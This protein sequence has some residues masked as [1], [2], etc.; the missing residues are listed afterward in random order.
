M[1]INKKKYW[2]ILNNIDIL[3]IV[4]TAPRPGTDFLH[5]LLDNHPEIISFD[6]WLHFH[7]FFYNSIT[8][9]GTKNKFFKEKNERFKNI[10]L[11]NFFYEFAWSHLH[12]FDSRYDN[13]EL[14]GNLGLKKNDFN[15]LDIDEFVKTAVTLIADQEFSCRN[16]MLAIYGSIIILRGDDLTTK[17]V[18]LHNVHLVDHLDLLVDDFP[19]VK[20]IACTR[21]PRVWATKINKTLDGLSLSKYSINMSRALFKL[22]IDSTDSL[23]LKKNNVRVN[24]LERLHERPLKTMKNICNW[25]G[26]KYSESLLQ[27]TWNGKVWNGDT[28]SDGIKKFF[29]SKRYSYS[30]KA[31]ERDMYVAERIA[32]ESIMK[33]EIATYGYKKYFNS[34]FWYFLAPILILPPTKYEIRI[35]S[36][37]FKSRNFQLL[38]YLLF[39]IF[40]RYYRSYKKLLNDYMKNISNISP[41]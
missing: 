17:K 33:K 5:S 10:N 11:T 28:L 36:Q 38:I 22:G 34:K 13:L 37:I 15:I 2:K 26:V 32:I 14:K 40:Y 24:I 4:A 39:N 21:D 12:K 3:T 20:I 25:I 1:A 35:F 23:N 19:N 16:A 9:Y 41:F 8:I 29:D 31:W 27:S 7:E 18:L 30:K 6:G